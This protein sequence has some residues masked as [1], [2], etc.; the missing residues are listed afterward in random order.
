E[1]VTPLLTGDA[2]KSNNF[3]S[4]KQWHANIQ[5]ESVQSAMIYNVFEVPALSPLQDTLVSDGSIVLLAC[6]PP[7]KSE[8]MTIYAHKVVQIMAS[9]MVKCS[10]VVFLLVELSDNS[11]TSVK[12]L[13]Q[14]R[15]AYLV[16]A[17][18]AATYDLYKRN[19]NLECLDFKGQ[20]GLGYGISS[21][22]ALKS[23]SEEG[24]LE[25][26]TASK[27][28]FQKTV[29]AA[30]IQCSKSVKEL[31]PWVHCEWSGALR[32]FIDDIPKMP[33]TTLEHISNQPD[34]ATQSTLHIRYA[35]ARVGKVINLLQNWGEAMFHWHPSNILCVSDMAA[36]ESL[37]K[38]LMCTPAPDKVKMC[39]SVNDMPCWRE[40]SLESFAKK[41]DNI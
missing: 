2:S 39:F 13:L 8:E 24:R 22:D 19:W 41:F 3:F 10:D 6:T 20:Q 35:Y 38:Q 7:H 33:A 25:I 40:D 15:I 27:E 4:Y 34:K 18:Q 17:L 1:T 11:N 37:L 30:L 21:L 16:G 23:L 14:T 31:V 32:E 29:S 12:D 28:N 5:S 26:V 9:V 36:Y